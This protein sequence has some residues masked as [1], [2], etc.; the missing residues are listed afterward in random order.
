MFIVNTVVGA[1]C[2]IV[3]GQSFYV[4]IAPW[5]MGATCLALGIANFYLAFKGI[6]S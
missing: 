3:A 2:V 5:W 1:F 4:G 6:S